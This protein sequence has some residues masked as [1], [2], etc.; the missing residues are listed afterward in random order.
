MNFSVFHPMNV[1]R[2]NSPQ[3][4]AQLGAAAGMV[5]IG[6]NMAMT[7]AKLVVGLLT[8]SISV[9]A[10]AL[11]N[12]SDAA[13]SAITLLGFR[14]ARRPAD[15][16]HPFGHARYEYLAG[17]AVAMLILT[18]G[19][20][21][22][23]SSVMKILHPEPITIRWYGITI[24]LA[25]VLL[26][27]WMYR[28]YSKLGASLHSGVL[29]ASGADSRNDALTT[30]AVIAACM[31]APRIPLP[32]DGIMGLLVAGF[33]LWSGFGVAQDM[34]TPLLGTQTDPALVHNLQTLLTSCPQVL[35]IHDL[36]VHDYGPGRCFASVHV[37]ISAGFN[38]LECHDIID[39]LEQQAAQQYGVSLVIHCDPVVLGNH[40]LEHLRQIVA[41]TLSELD[42]S[43]S[44][45]DL[46]MN[47]QGQLSFDVELPFACT[48]Q[49]QT[50]L[51]A[52]EKQLDSVPLSIQFDRIPSEK[53]SE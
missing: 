45:H 22:L 40:L 49:P 20:E 39:M 9:T 34:I 33:I 27:F 32:L 3:K 19:A 41:K 15:E 43:L 36:L 12:F 8:H 28:F 21:L 7:I 26:K 53:G 37:E 29:I 2:A 46:R 14:L 13:A 30:L 48:I 4:R 11:N 50:I 6:C 23:K 47:E 52:L 31:L 18:V 17:L 10:D 5:G 24:L 35:G 25:S 1:T 38:A 51:G 44:F 42:S 16:E